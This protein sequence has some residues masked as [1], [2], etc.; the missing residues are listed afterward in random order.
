M[1]EEI[2]E[3][4]EL[5]PEEYAEARKKAIEHLKKEITYLKVEKEYESL[6]ADVE[7]AKTRRISMVA[8]QARFFAPPAEAPPE[9][10]AAPTRAE[11]PPAQ[12]KRTLKK[13]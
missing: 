7:E 9:G 2:T 4:T 11:A 3:E 12:P 6:M 5:S 1:S 10:E 8:Q 13:S